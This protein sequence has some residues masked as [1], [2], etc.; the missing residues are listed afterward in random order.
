MGD[1]DRCVYCGEIIPEGR[2]ICPMCESII[3][4]TKTGRRLSWW[5]R[6]R[7]KF[8]SFWRNWKSKV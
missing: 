7:R 4:P 8:L 2:L 1:A 3:N 5:K 6:L